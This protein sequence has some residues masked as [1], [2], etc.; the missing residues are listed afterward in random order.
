MQDKAEKRICQNCKN[1]FI[2]EP[3]DFLFYEKIKVPPPTFCS[4]CRL[5]RRLV[6]MKGIELYKRKCD[7]CGE[8]K[9]SMYHPNA[10]Y[11]VYCD[12]CW[13]SDNWDAKDFYVDYDSKRTFF[14]QWN[15]LLHKTPILGLS[16]DST[17]GELS[18]YTNHVGNS[19]NCYLI[20]YSDYGEDSAFGY[21]FTH[22]KNV[23]NSGSIMECDT[24]YDS[25]NLFKSYNIIGGA[26]NNTTSYDC[27]FIRD[28]EGAHHCFIATNIRNQS[29]IYEGQKITKEEYEEKLKEIDLGSYKQYQFWK[30]KA[31]DYFKNSI[32]RPNWE[33]LAV[34]S[35]GSYVF[36]SKNCKECYDVTDCEDS[37]FLM[38]IKIGKVKDSYDYVDWGENAELIYEGIT[39]GNGANNVKFSHESGHNIRDIEYSKLSTGGSHHF[40]CVSIKKTEYCI[41]NKQYTKEEYKKLR[42][43]IIEDMN[44][45]PYINNLGHIYKYGEFF[46]LEFS[47]H[48]YNDTFAS[49][50]FP[51]L[52]VEVI[53]RGL[54][55][56]EPE[57]KEYAI[58]IPSSDLPDHIKDVS[59]SIKNEIIGCSQCKRGFRIINQELQFLRQHNLP[60]S[61][62][63][64]FC[65]IWDKVNVLALNMKLFKRTC[66]KCNNPFSTHYSKERAPIIYC[67]KC[68]KSEF[69]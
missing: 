18:P 52:E 68:Y 65:R 55:W 28:C 63:C 49:K 5:Q 3:D 26:S 16:I 8:M 58:T 14:E 51:L 35:T 7:L 29:Y 69:L 41:L 20:Y 56:Y 54:R 46:P 9:L 64:P 39:I 53:D 66:H 42:N 21:Q 25:S 34:N 32:P 43:E 22:V 61:R 2:I 31:K 47:P 10:P 15:E 23:Y 11:V 38:L 1:D 30:N 24:V 17:T 62:S 27:A 48:F 40:G 59:D 33:T 12:R 6:W 36:Q 44:N 50:L 37:K 67:M 13:W 45:N 60:L 57:D 19:K 4:E